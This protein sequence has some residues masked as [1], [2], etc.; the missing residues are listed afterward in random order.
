MVK[1]DLKNIQSGINFFD[2]IIVYKKN[3]NIVNV[4]ENSCDHMGG[5]FTKCTEDC[6]VT[7]MRHNWKLNLE[8]LNLKFL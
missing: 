4:C 8:I 5:R 3:D 2:N 6:M 7:C 1:F